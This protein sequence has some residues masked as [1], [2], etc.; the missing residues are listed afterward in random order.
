MVALGIALLGLYLFHFT[1]W[2]LDKGI[3]DA[4]RCGTAIVVG[5][6][7]LLHPNALNDAF[8]AAREPP[9]NPHQRQ[10]SRTCNIRQGVLL[11]GTIV[12]VDK[13]DSPQQ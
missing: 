12:L 1:A 7:N 13:E 11:G 9:E 10:D 8:V 3:G 5:V 2:R 6:H 4:P